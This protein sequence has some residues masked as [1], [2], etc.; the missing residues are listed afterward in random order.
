[1]PPS[2]PAEF[3]KTES[4]FI[5]KIQV[6]QIDGSIWI[7]NSVIHETISRRGA[8]PEKKTLKTGFGQFFDKKLHTKI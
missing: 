7:G 6:Y 4:K 5:D 1:M 3:P 2:E 8:T